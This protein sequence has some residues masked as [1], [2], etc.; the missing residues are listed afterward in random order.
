LAGYSFDLTERWNLI[1]KVGYSRWRLDSTEGW[2]LNP[3]DEAQ[4]TTSGSDFT[5][6]LTATYEVFFM[7]YQGTNFDFGRGR[8]LIFGANINF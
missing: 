3:G 4:K 6:M 8:A 1:P 2:V 7:T 5:Y